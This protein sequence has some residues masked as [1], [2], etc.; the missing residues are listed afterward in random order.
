MG[1]VHEG[2]A[3][4][5]YLPEEQERGITI[6]AAPR[7]PARGATSPINLIDTPGHVDFTAE[8]ERSLRVLD[9][10]VVV[11]DGVAG[12]EA[13]SRDRLAPGRPLPASRA[14]ASSTRWTAAGAD[15][16]R[17]LASIR[18]RLGARA[19]RRADRP[20]ARAGLRRRH[21]P[22]RA[23]GRA[24]AE[25]SRARRSC[26]S[27]IPD[28]ARRTRRSSA[29]RE[30]VEAARRPRRRRR[31]SA[32]SPAATVLGPSCS[33][34]LREATLAGAALPGAL[35]RGAP[36]QG[37]PA[38]ARRGRR[39][40]A[41][42]ARRPARSRATTP[43]RAPR[44]VAVA[45]DPE[46]P[47][48]RARLQDRRPTARRPHVRCASTAARSSSGQG[49]VQPAP[50]EA[51]A[52][53]IAQLYRMHAERARA[54]R[55]GASRATS[56]RWSGLKLRGHRRHAL[57]R[58]RAR[59]R[60]SRCTFPEPVISMAIEPKSDAD[61]DQLER[62]ARRGSRARTRRSAP[63][64]RGDRPDDHRRDG[65]AP[66]RGPDEPAD[67]RLRRQRERREPARR[68][69]PDDRSRGAGEGALRAGSAANRMQFAHLA[70]EAAPLER[71]EGFKVEWDDRV[72]GLRPAPDPARRW[73]GRSPT[74]PGAGRAAAYPRDRRPLQGHRGDASDEERVHASSP[75][76][77]PP[78]RAFEAAAETAGTGA[79]RADHA[80]RGPHAERVRGRRPRR[81]EP[82]RGDASTGDRAAG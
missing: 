6:T 22:R 72:R 76:R 17:A 54:A 60:S 23:R 21:R 69:P 27:P 11:F 30:L 65:G 51:R 49:A 32:S 28:G 74:P 45:P 64:R 18:T 1:E 4:M 70:V 78:P 39:L 36:Q 75:S 40:P 2:T 57:R 37:R 16:E 56:S 15:F 3:T 35:R 25:A 41:R 34:A 12:V 62:G 26:A 80:V 38:A 14:S 82:P 46:A 48:R 66:P 81:P 20:S 42:P 9:G 24:L 50:R 44:S 61:R 67:A 73:S 58:R 53:A 5:D 8:V 19:A 63:R 13:Q 10:A 79:P 59:S 29:A 43:R 7:P 31:P 77:R 68:L 52:S 71:H 55:G 33:A 47:V